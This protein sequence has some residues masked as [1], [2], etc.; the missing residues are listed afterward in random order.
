MECKFTCFDRVIHLTEKLPA[1]KWQEAYDITLEHGLQ[2]FLDFCVENGCFTQDQADVLYAH[3]IM[4]EDLEGN[5][6]EED[7][8]KLQELYEAVGLTREV[9]EICSNEGG[10]QIN[11]DKIIDKAIEFC[12]E[13]YEKYDNNREID[14]TDI[15]YIIEILK[16]RE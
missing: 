1:S 3:I 7:Y 2:E 4:W 8:N 15:A 10:V 14:D 5:Y 16:G 9:C 11:K 6:Y 12:Y 13:L